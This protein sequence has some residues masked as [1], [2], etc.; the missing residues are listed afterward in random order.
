MVFTF[1]IEDAR[2]L[3]GFLASIVVPFA[4]A[5]IKS[6]DWSPSAKLA[7]AIV[8]SAA[9]ALLSQYIAGALIGT[10]T[11]PISLISAIIGVFLAGQAHYASWFQGLGLD[12]ALAPGEAEPSTAA[13]RG[14]L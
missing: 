6:A 2:L 1:T 5:K 9:A 14:R 11:A 12:D 8:V 10:P 4:T 7:L 13:A 3:A